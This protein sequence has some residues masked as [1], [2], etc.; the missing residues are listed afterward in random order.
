METDIPLRDIMVREVVTGDE[1]MNVREAA[2][3][4]RKYDVDS[5]VVLNNSGQP[6][7]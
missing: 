6:G 7:V 3:L 4:M 2:K 5:I 1:D